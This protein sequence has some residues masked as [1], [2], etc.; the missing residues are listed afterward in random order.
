MNGLTIKHYSCSSE[1]KAIKS[2]CEWQ[3]IYVEIK[4]KSGEAL[5]AT[6]G[7]GTPVVYNSKT[8]EIVAIGF[9]DFVE[10]LKKNGLLLC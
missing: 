4:D 7:H 10:Y 2:V 9:F 3:N 6:H 5:K 1:A 8:D